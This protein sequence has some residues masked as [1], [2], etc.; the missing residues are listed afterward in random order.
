MGNELVG[1]LVKATEFAESHSVAAGEKPLALVVALKILE[2]HASI[3]EFDNMAEWYAVADDY[4]NNLALNSPPR[5]VPNEFQVA[6]LHGIDGAFYKEYTYF[7]EVV[8]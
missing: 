7:L 2:H 5:G 4:D 3:D 8:A 6:L 1:K